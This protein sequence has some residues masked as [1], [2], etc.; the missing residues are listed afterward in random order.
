MK[1]VIAMICN[2]HLLTIIMFLAL[3][4]CI[5]P[6]CA[7]A[8]SYARIPEGDYKLNSKVKSNMM[9]DVNGGGSADGANIQIYQNNY[10]S[11]AQIYRITHVKDGWH[12]IC[13]VASGKAVDVAGGSKKSGT[14]VH[15][16]KYNGS[17]AQ[18]WRFYPVSSGYYQIQNKLKCYLDVA[19]GG[20]S[21]GT[22][23]CVYAKNSSNAQKWKLINEKQANI[24]KK[25]Y[26]I[27]TKL[28]SNMML[29][30]DG[31]S[32]LDGANIHIYH[33]ND[34]SMA[35][36]F[37]IEHVKDGWYR[38]RNVASNKVVDVESGS[39]K[40][41]TNVRQHTYNGTA[42]QLWRFYSVSGG[43]YIRSKLGC[44][45]DVNGGSNWDGANVQV[46]KKNDSN[47][48]KWKLIPQVLPTKVTLNVSA[49][50][51]DK[52]GASKKITAT[53]APANATQKTI[54]WSTSNSKVATVTKDGTV[55][56]I[57]SGQATVTARTA[58][59]KTA[60]AQIKVDD[61]CVEIDE[62]YYSINTKLASNMML[63]VAGNGAVDGANVQICASNDTNAQKFRVRK[64]GNGWYELI[65]T[66]PS[67][68]LDVAGG[69]NWNGANVQIHKSNGTAAQRW[70]FYRAE[71]GYYYIMNQTGRY[72]DVH[73]A[74]KNNGANVVIWEKNSSAAQQW[75]FVK[76]NQAHVNIANGLYRI[77]AKTGKNLA[78]DVAGSGWADGTNIQIHEYNNSMAQ[79]FT[80]QNTDDG[81]YKLVNAF[82]GKCLD[83]AG[84][85]ANNGTNV[86]LCSDNGTNAQK[87]RFYPSGDG[88]C[89]IIKSK[90]GTNLCL[91]VAGGGTNNGTNVAIWEQNGSAAQKWELAEAKI[92]ELR[93]IGLNSGDFTMDKIGATK[94]LSVSYEPSNASAAGTAVSW[95]SS[96]TSVARVTNGVVTAVGAGSAKITAKSYNGKTASVMVTVVSETQSVGYANPVRSANAKWSKSIESS[97]GCQH[98]IQNVPQGTPVYAIDNGTIICQQRYEVIGGV[99]KLVSYGNVI[100]FTSSDGKTTAKYAHLSRFEKCGLLVPSNQ[101]VK[102]GWS[103]ATKT[104]TCGNYSVRKGE[105]IGYVGTTGN[106]TAPH[107][108][109]E[110]KINGVRKNPPNY[111]KIN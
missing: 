8:A 38:I 67:T 37:V 40:S 68:C 99:K 25:T 82:S 74:N 9:L 15:Q 96:N 65:N 44:Y 49:V 92:I 21:N 32:S 83:V 79:M 19:G 87:W 54:L 56:A 22:N 73:A 6:V 24:A 77:S 66:Y 41:G 94:N 84:A 86:Q 78:L 71:N 51:L 18:L 63:D 34:D 16:Y 88:N 98:D 10:D 89:F 81:W 72:L 104:H 3:S 20:K 60:K 64:V 101:T 53:V 5:K 58:N 110:I 62:D 1:K 108:H 42:A 69:S 103:G 57:G 39:T 85:G 35:Q 26:K 27:N 105:C 61:G 31:G 48:Q 109:F 59:G 90:V 4:A 12:K 111:V 17:D 106:S 100:D 30:V 80:V 107:L 23:V 33:D 91:D 50:T 102:K 36:Q 45:L 29:D 2:K 52:I 14:N 70:R 11:Y 28:K 97:S 47:A 7:S 55:K 95:E 75:K 93:G 76:T 13:N 46:H 43:Y